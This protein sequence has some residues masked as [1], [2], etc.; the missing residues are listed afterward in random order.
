MKKEV[1]RRFAVVWIA[2]VLLCLGD[3]QLAH[4][5]LQDAPRTAGKRY[6]GPFSDLYPP[7]WTQPSR[8]IPQFVHGR[9][10]NGISGSPVVGAKVASSKSKTTTNENGEYRLSVTSSDRKLHVLAI[11]YPAATET[12]EIGA[13]ELVEH[14]IPLAPGTLVRL[15]CFDAD[16]GLALSRV[17]VT[18]DGHEEAQ[19]TNAFGETWLAVLDDRELSLTVELEGFAKAHC[20]W[21]AHQLAQLDCLHVALRAVGWIEVHVVEESGTPV[22]GTNLFPLQEDELPSVSS[23]GAER[24]EPG[25]STHADHRALERC[26]TTNE[27]GVARIAVLPGSRPIRVRYLGDAYVT[28]STGSIYV[29][30]AGLTQVVELKLEAGSSLS[31]AIRLNGLAYGDGRISLR[32]KASGMHT[33]ANVD[34]YGHYVMAHVPEGEVV[35]YFDPGGF[36]SGSMPVQEQ[37][38]VVEKNMSHRL[39]FAWSETRVPLRGQLLDAM[40]MPVPN[41]VVSATWNSP[42]SHFRFFSAWS[43]ANGRFEL[44]VPADGV[45]F[46]YTKSNLAD[47]YIPGVLPGAENV[48][49]VLREFG[50]VTLAVCNA[51]TGEPVDLARIAYGDLKW[52]DSRSEPYEA[53]KNFESFLGRIIL[54]T[55]MRSEAQIDLMV[56]LGG[57]GYDSVERLGLVVTPA[58]QAGPIYELALPPSGSVSKEL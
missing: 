34:P 53:C 46:L 12:I 51:A 4:G 38:L 26:C 15:K 31:G 14:T 50:H 3:S 58:G 25:N 57:L 35:V 29:R 17:R 16:S 39:D 21:Q 10:V 32:H 37:Q 45:Y 5:G 18:P 22:R 49:L 41:H 13:R 1:L 19:E 47:A 56:E 33:H 24:T 42:N 20:M 23:R 11:G 30:T 36:E 28:A 48:Q 6:F 7:P 2:L 43:G 9:V 52:R 54:Q 40:G 8:P 27:F 44:Q 55:P